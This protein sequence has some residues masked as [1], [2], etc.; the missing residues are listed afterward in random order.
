[1]LFSINVDEKVEN[2]ASEDV[3]MQVILHPKYQNILLT[4]HLLN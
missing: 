2:V 1:M 4:S 3:L